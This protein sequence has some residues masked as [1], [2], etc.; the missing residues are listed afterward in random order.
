MKHDGLP[1]A[2]VILIENGKVLLVR[3]EEGAS[4]MNGTYAIPSGRPEEGEAPIATAN[5]EFHEETGLE[6]SI[7][8]LKAY[9]NNVYTAT[10]DRKDGTRK[11]YSMTVFI[12]TKYWGSLKPSSETTPQ[13]VEIKKM[14]NLNL[15]AN[16]EKIVA[17]GLKYKNG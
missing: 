6:T 10:F 9:P 14:G 11:K 13:W 12:C 7:E 5:R 2:G 8:F 4:H 1:A 16:N 15:L 17:D 3:H